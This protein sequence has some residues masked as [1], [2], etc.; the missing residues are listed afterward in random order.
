MSYI[1]VIKLVIL[2]IIYFNCNFLTENGF[3]GCATTILYHG[4]NE[5]PSGW[6]MVSGVIHHLI[7]RAD[8]LN[9]SIS[10]TRD[11]NVIIGT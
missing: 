5:V 6:F 4:F 10:N 1:Y 9:Q 7:K 2:P 11:D 8:T 3:N